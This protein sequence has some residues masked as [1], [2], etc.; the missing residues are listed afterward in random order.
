MTQ[1]FFMIIVDGIPW[2]DSDGNDMWPSR[3][4]YGLADLIEDQGYDD[5]EIV[6]A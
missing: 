4:V 1:Q 5:I 3:E 6:P 2:E